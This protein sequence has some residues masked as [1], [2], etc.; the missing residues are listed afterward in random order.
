[1]RVN[2]VVTNLRLPLDAF[3]R[4]VERPGHNDRNWKP[5]SKQDDG[6]PGG[7]DRKFEYRKDDG[8]DLQQQ[9]AD[10]NVYCRNL[11]DVSSF[12]FGQQTVH[13]YS[14]QICDDPS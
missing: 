14:L 11:K 9:P 13:K 1:M 10:D 8:Y 3:G 12:E 2:V 7:P 5:Q 6:E 4:Q